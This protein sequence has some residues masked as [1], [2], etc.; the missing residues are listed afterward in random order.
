MNIIFKVFLW[1]RLGFV[2]NLI[3]LCKLPDNEKNKYQQKNA[4]GKPYNKKPKAKLFH[5]AAQNVCVSLFFP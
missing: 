4:A 1:C 5:S 3:A 2:K